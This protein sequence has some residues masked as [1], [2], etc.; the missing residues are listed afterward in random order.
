MHEQAASEV[1]TLSALLDN[2]DLRFVLTRLG[3]AGTL[4]RNN[5]ETSPALVPL[6]L[7]KVRAQ[8]SHCGKN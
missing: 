7:E 5:K 1:V 3:D 2:C 4:L 8:C 6:C